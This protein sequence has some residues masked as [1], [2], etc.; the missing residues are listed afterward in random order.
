MKQWVS[1]QELV[2]V[3]GLSKNDRVIRRTAEKEDW[4]SQTRPGRAKE[5]EYAFSSLP[6]GV[7]AALALRWW[8]AETKDGPIQKAKEGDPLSDLRWDAFLRLPKSQQAVGRKHMAA[9]MALLELERNGASRNQAIATLQ[10]QGVVHSRMT[11]FRWLKSV[12]GHPKTEWLPLLASQHSGGNQPA[13]CPPDAWEAFKADYLRLEKP[14]ASACYRRLKEAASRQGWTL[15]SY[16]TLRLRLR[17]EVGA[18]AIILAR[19]GKAA[20]ARLYPAQKR[21]VADLFALAL[22]C[23]DGHSFDVF[24]KWAGIEKLVR[25][26]LLGLQDVYSRKILAWRIGLNENAALVR[27]AF[28][29]LLRDWADYTLLKNH[30]QPK[31]Q[32]V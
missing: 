21:S 28:A 20:L 29:D 18:E 4:P 7:Q 23:G 13:H 25:P 16:D 27:L 30:P 17:T 12:K 5:K 32:R 10:S 11:F 22:V 14:A 26:M 6:Q 3:A 19:E 24:T 31:A 15:P 9:L 2:G 1:A 8:A